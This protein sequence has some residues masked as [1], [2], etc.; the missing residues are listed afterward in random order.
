MSNPVCYC[1]LSHA[2]PVKR[3]NPALSSHMTTSDNGNEV[4]EQNST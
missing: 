4:V 3:G 2:D 1:S